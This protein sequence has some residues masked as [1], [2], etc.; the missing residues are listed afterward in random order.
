[1]LTLVWPPM[2]FA[3]ALHVELQ[4]AV[5]YTAKV[6]KHSCRRDWSFV[7]GRVAVDLGNSAAGFGIRAE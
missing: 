7:V 3:V 5:G 1:M 2:E 6:W 4:V